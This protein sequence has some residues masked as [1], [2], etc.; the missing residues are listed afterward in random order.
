MSIIFKT[1]L[2]YSLYW[3]PRRYF[4]ITESLLWTFSKRKPNHIIFLWLIQLGEGKAEGHRCSQR[5]DSICMANVTWALLQPLATHTKP[6]KARLAL[7]C[8][9][10]PKEKL[11]VT[12][13][14]PQAQRKPEGEQ[15]WTGFCHGSSGD[16]KRNFYFQIL[17]VLTT[18]LGKQREKCVVSLC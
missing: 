15:P 4:F 18:T 6:Q 2:R 11:Y 12:L 5:T 1:P 14:K 17:N 9:P 16:V 7:D 10:L 8:A 13:S 3:V